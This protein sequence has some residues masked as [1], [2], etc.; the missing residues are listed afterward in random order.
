MQLELE[1]QLSIYVKFALECNN[2]DKE[3]I[4][5]VRQRARLIRKTIVQCHWGSKGK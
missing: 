5:E 1:L 2:R 4:E 3:E